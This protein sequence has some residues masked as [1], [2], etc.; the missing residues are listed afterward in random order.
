MAITPRTARRLVLIAATLLVGAA[1]PD[2]GP[3]AA[4]APD[5][6]TR[7]QPPALSSSAAA[8]KQYCVT[9]HS[10]RLKSGNFVID[11]GGLGDVG[12]AGDRWEKV[13]RKLRTQAMPPP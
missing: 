8:L 6:V 2:I 13:V 1:G 7:T 11:P 9:C 5:P 10:E 12:A 3:I 4:Q